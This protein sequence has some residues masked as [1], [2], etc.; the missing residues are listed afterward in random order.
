M[1]DF[2]CSFDRIVRAQCIGSIISIETQMTLDGVTHR[3]C[4][5]SKSIVEIGPTI[6]VLLSPES[7]PQRAIVHENAY[8]DFVEA[9]KKLVKDGESF[10]TALRPGWALPDFLWEKVQG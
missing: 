2:D 4:G 8:R 7:T 10:Y 3:L 9:A 5:R 1:N 6:V